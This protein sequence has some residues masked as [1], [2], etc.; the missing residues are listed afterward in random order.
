MALVFQRAD[1]GRLDFSVL[2]G[3]RKKR[4]LLKSVLVRKSGLYWDYIQLVTVT[5]Y[6]MADLIDRSIRM[7]FTNNIAVLYTIHNYYHRFASKQNTKTH[8]RQLLQTISQYTTRNPQSVIHL[9]MPTVILLYKTIL[10]Q[11]RS[12]NISLCSL[13]TSNFFLNKIRKH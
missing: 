11:S 10:A 9:F 7:L 4:R 2:T 8:G 12:H 1:S 3:N 13:G 6:T 5:L